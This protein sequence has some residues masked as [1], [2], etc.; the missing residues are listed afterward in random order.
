MTTHLLLAEEPSKT[1]VAVAHVVKML[2]TSAIRLTDLSIL[3]LF[4][5]S[6]LWSKNRRTVRFIQ[7]SKTGERKK[8]LILV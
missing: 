6:Q 7:H 2:E 1:V 4:F 5:F 8:S 3:A